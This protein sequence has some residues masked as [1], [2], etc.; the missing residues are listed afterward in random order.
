VKAVCARGDPSTMQPIRTPKEEYVEQLFA[1]IAPRYDLLNSVLS[2]NL[3]KRWRR[4]A[5]RECRLSPGDAALDVAAGT[6]DLSIEMAKVG[7]VGGSV[8]AVDFCL[9]MLEIGR[10]KLDT[11][12]ISVIGGNAERL[13]V[14]PDSFQAA[15]IGFG[16]RNV[17][18]VERT[19]AEMTRTVRPGGRVVS[20]ELARPT[21]PLFSR[22][23]NLYFHRLLPMIGGLVNGRT[24]PYAYLPASVARFHSRE[25]LAAIMEK[26]GLVDIKVHDLTGGVAAVHV[27]TK[28]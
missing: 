2:F 3:H 17:E 7:G 21:G 20:L 8:I 18:N 26:V 22:I 14:P 27:G 10:K 23:Y 25:E 15:I 9:P 12:N 5:V 4:I 11:P 13:P 28:R 6:L 24:E 1:S 16:L 19:L